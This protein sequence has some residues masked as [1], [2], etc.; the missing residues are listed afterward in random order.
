GGT[1]SLVCIAGHGTERRGNQAPLQREGIVAFGHVV[2]FLGK[3]VCK[4]TLIEG[5]HH[6][7]QREPRTKPPAADY[8]RDDVYHS[9]SC[10]LAEPSRSRCRQCLRCPSSN[11][12]IGF[13]AC[14]TRGCFLEPVARPHGQA[15][16]GSSRRLCRTRNRPGKP[17]E[18]A[19][20][21]TNV[22]DCHWNF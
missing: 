9:G 22:F 13:D 2:F 1:G 6:E 4:Y 15:L 8:N 12:G 16:G 18:S 10:G 7:R 19:E 17:V 14:R 11:C 5:E 3:M 20:E 21:S